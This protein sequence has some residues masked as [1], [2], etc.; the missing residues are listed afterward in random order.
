M[1]VYIPIAFY[2]E[3]LGCYTAYQRAFDRLLDEVRPPNP[4]AIWDDLY[5]AS[6]LTCEIDSDEGPKIEMMEPF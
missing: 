6:I 2:N 1:R 4:Q 5:G 3:V